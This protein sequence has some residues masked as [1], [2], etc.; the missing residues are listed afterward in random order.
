LRWDIVPGDPMD[1][2]ITL[3][4][5]EPQETSKLAREFMIK[6]RKRKGLAENVSYH[7]YFDDEMFHAFAAQYNDE[8]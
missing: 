2:T 3:L 5:L 4:P 6:T 7:K 1:E 8:K